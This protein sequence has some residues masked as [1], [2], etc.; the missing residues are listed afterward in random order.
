[1]H[2]LSFFQK[3]L[4]RRKCSARACALSCCWMG[5]F[6]LRPDVSSE[7]VCDVHDEGTLNREEP[8]TGCCALGSTQS[9]NSNRREAAL[10]AH[11]CSRVQRC[12]HLHA[13]S[14]ATPCMH[15]L[16]KSNSKAMRRNRRCMRQKGVVDAYA[17][18]ISVDLLRPLLL[19]LYLPLTSL[20]SFLLPDPI[21]RP[22]RFL[23]VGFRCQERSKF[24]N[25]ELACSSASLQSDR[26]FIVLLLARPSHSI[27]F[28]SS[29][30]HLMKRA[31]A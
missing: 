1:M 23:F 3:V 26:H 19:L 13:A 21:T 20:A 11:G 22:S 27:K 2:A 4:N 10:C 5:V 9:N 29:A 31:S 7:R 24:T 17:N 15:R 28:T 18:S 30:I 16:Q 8:K 14:E 12:A 6:L 25:W